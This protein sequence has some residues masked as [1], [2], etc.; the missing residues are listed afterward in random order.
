MYLRVRADKKKSASSLAIQLQTTLRKQNFKGTVLVIKNNKKYLSY[1]KGLANQ[2]SNK[3]NG[4]DTTY[5][6]NSVQKTM[7]ATMLM[8][9]VEVHKVSLTDKLSQFYPHVPGSSKITLRQMLQMASGLVYTGD[10]FGTPKYKNDAAGIKYDLS[11]IKFDQKSYG[12]RTYQPINYVLLT[13]IVEKV[14]HESYEKLFIKTFVKPLKL[15]ETAFIWS[16]DK[17]LAKARLAKSYSEK[18]KPVELNMN[19]L[20]GEFGTGSIIM[21]NSDLYKC[22]KAMLDGTLLSETARNSLFQGS[23]N[24]VQGGNYGGGFYNFP[25]YHA[26]SGAGYGY[27]NFVCVSNDGKNAIIIQT[28]SPVKDYFKLRSDMHGLIEALQGE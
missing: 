2:A 17:S 20:H 19:E 14:N 12:R 6:I 25:T 22:L 13:G 21:S 1:S 7:T 15:K 26:A 23:D 11:K 24:N 8:Q 10:G 5:L 18:N 3:A 27:T 9:A 16:K 28:N 4:A